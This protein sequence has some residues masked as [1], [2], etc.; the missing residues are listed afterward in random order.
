VGGGPEINCGTILFGGGG[1][2]VVYRKM[3]D[4]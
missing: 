3:L 4:G 1:L 2:D